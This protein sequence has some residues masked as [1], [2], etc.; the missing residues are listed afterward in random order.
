M[1]LM[2]LVRSQ[3]PPPQKTRYHDVTDADVAQV[4]ERLHGKEKVA[5]STPAVGTKNL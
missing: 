1:I 2:S 3:L 4:A 5:G